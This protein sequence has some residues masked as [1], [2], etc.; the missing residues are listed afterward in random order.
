MFTALNY[1]HYCPQ[2]RKHQVWFFFLQIYVWKLKKN[3]FR[4][5]KSKFFVLN[6]SWRSLREVSSELPLLLLIF[7]WRL[8]SWEGRSLGCQTDILLWRRA[9]SARNRR[10]AA[11][12]A[13][14]QGNDLEAARRSLHRKWGCPALPRFSPSGQLKQKRTTP[15]LGWLQAGKPQAG[16]RSPHVS[17]RA[18]REICLQFLK[19]HEAANF[20]L[21]LA[22]VKN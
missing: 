16:F 7:T 19:E 8:I 13:E 21:I 11:V 14:L 15:T 20:F 3:D 1:T 12:G 6:S 22:T 9:G 17:F 5:K 2:I 18:A 10:S 4:R